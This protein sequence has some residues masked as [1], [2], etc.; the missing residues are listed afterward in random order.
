MF[1]FALLL[2]LL[3]PL[4]GQNWWLRDA[5]DGTPVIVDIGVK[6]DVL[7]GVG[8]TIPLGTSIQGASEIKEGDET[9]YT[10]YPDIA[11]NSRCRVSGRSTAL[12]HKDN[13]GSLFLAVLN[14][15]FARDDLTFEQLVEVE[16]YLI[17]TDARWRTEVGREQIAGQLQ[18]SWLQL[19]TRALGSEGFR[20]DQPLVES[21]I[22]QSDVLQTRRQKLLPAENA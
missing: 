14:H 3:H 12:W 2:F 18:F 8:I 21:W 19:I 1:R 10:G 7:P 4:Q 20:P 13:P 15:A 9:F 16:N 6:C 17:R 5:A 22:I 11:P